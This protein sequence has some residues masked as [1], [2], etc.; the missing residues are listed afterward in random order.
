MMHPRQITYFAWMGEEL[1]TVQHFPAWVCD[2]CGKREYD[3]KAIAWLKML[4]NPNAGRPMSHRRR[5]PPAT[6]P[7]TSSS[8][9][10]P[11][12]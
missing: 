5:K 11:D 7:R 8:R 2:L 1:I 4:L 10:I 3:E 12:S 6:R 9:P